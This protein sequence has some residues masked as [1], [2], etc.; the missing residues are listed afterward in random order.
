MTVAPILDFVMSNSA[1]NPLITIAIPT[2][3]RASWLTGCVASAL[4]QTYPNFE[5][6][7]SDNASTDGTDETLKGFSDRRLHAIRQETNIGLIP[8]W[9][10]CLAEARGDYIVFVSDDDRI[11]PWMLERCAAL[12]KADP[13]I[14]VVVALCDTQFISEG[15]T[16]PAIPSRKLGTG[17]WNGTDILLE[18]LEGRLFAPMCTVIMQTAA[19]RAREGFPI[20]W[21]HLAD[22]ATW[23]PMLFTGTGWFRQ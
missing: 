15:Y 9:N 23:V 7:V 3:N 8:N 11:A 18:I 1:N 22:K 19:L 14:P 2:F 12:M 13:Q 4:S 21:P 6:V 16:M 17:I 20:D 5:V 10:A